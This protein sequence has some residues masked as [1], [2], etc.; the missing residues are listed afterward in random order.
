[1]IAR[2][3]VLA[4]LVASLTLAGEATARGAE[5]NAVIAG[6]AVGAVVGGVIVA[7]G[8]YNR[9]PVYVEIGTPPP[10]VYY[11]SYPRYY[12]PPPVYYRPYPIEV[13]PYYQYRPNHR[14]RQHQHHYRK[15]RRHYRGYS[16]PRW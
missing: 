4:V 14:F 12:Q 2:I 15:H 10:H 6:A 16:T 8:R 5:R 7:N 11:E 13:R 9:L 1:M 3:P